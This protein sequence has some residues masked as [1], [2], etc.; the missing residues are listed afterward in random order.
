[1]NSTLIVIAIAA[2]IFFALVFLAVNAFGTRLT[3]K[4]IEDDP[5]VRKDV[6]PE[7]RGDDFPVDA[8]F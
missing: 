3:G 5:E 4:Q 1:M 7:Q 2:L 6:D 8:D